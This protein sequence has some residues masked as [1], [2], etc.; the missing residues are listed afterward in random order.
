MF[1]RRSFERRLLL[2]LVLFS[3][4][5]SLALLGAG[6]YLLSEAV[7][8]RT[9]AV[10]F[11]RI[12]E[13]GAPLVELGEQSEDAGLREAAA[14]HREALS[15]S[16]LQSGRWDYLNE[17]MLG[18]IP[19]LSLLLSGLLVWLAVRSARSI[20]RGLS[21]PIH[22]LVGWAE[23]LAREE[24]LPPARSGRRRPDEFAALRQAFRTMEGELSASRDR[25][26]EA[27]RGRAWVTMARGVAHELKNSLTPL[28][29]ATRSLGGRLFDDPAANESLEVMAAESE[30]LEELARAFSRF[31]SVPE[32]PLSEIDVAEQLGYLVRVHVPEGV[33][34]RM[35]IEPDPPR[36]TGHHDALSGALANLLINAVEAAGAGGEVRIQVGV[37]ERT[38]GQPGIS[39]RYL[40]IAIA[41]SGPGIAPEHL[42]RLWEPDFSTKPRG[43]GLGLALVKQTILHHGGRVDAANQAGGGAEFIVE[44]PL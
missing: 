43:T 8:L 7:E 31:G 39:G 11:E 30:R 32:G 12:A 5:P 38:D 13:T 16:L 40:R 20:S 26:L 1:P 18:V 37:R 41:D 23:L 44:L 3:L 14:E 22:Q 9:S 4:V 34:Y 21:R 10:T 24:P 27:E 17:R 6:T 36:V 29:L 2:A 15:N 35:E 19:W 28:R 25:A 33:T 42:Q